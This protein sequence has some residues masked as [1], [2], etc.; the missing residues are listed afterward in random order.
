MMVD[1]CVEAVNFWTL[2]NCC[3]SQLLKPAL[4]RPNL[5][6]LD[7][8]SE[9]DGQGAFQPGPDNSSELSYSVKRATLST[10]LP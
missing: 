2:V 3:R 7:L 9:G 8:C 4:V 5:A 1:Q 6:A 10:Y